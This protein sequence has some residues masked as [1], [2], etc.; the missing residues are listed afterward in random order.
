M[1]WGSGWRGSS[2]GPYRYIAPSRFGYL[3]S[4]R[5]SDQTPDAQADLYAALLDLLKIDSIVIIGLSG[6]GA[7]APQFALRHPTR[8]C[9]LLVISAISRQVP[10]LPRF[11][12]A[13]FPIML[14][15]DFL[16]WFLHAVA[17][18]RIYRL[19]GS[20]VRCSRESKKTGRRCG[21]WMRFSRPTFP[22][23][24]GGRGCSA[25]CSR[26]RTPFDP[27][28]ADLHPYACDPRGG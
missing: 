13:I 18:R 28:G 20:A 3:R 22:P 10:P 17:P 2:G 14:S 15:S 16:P 1:I 25:T 12:R 6:G 23:H 26:W 27:V 24:R 11:L 5:P 8:C 21:R 19:T 9:G 4:P 7:S